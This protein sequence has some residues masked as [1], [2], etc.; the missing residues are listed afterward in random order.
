MS[1]WKLWDCQYK[2]RLYRTT[3]N[4]K[5]SLWNRHTAIMTGATRTV[6]EG[7]LRANSKAIRARARRQPGLR[8]DTAINNWPRTALL[9]MRQL[10]P[11]TGLHITFTCTLHNAQRNR[12]LA[13]KSTWEELDTPNEIRVDTNEYEDGGH[14]F[15][16]LPFRLPHLG[17]VIT[18][19]VRFMYLLGWKFHHIDLRG[20][21]INWVS[22]WIR[23]RFGAGV[24]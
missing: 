14:D 17:A 3:I 2:N 9:P 10:H 15:L 7:G 6:T 20:N 1:L 23:P 19:P 13:G 21:P 16:F 8:L 18:H 11:Q 22:P 12:L 5:L 4:Q 24:L